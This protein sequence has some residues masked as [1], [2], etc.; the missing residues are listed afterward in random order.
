MEEE[1]LDV[2]QDALLIY[3]RQ[4]KKGQL[5]NLQASVGTYLFGIG[6]NLLRKLKVKQKREIQLEENSFS[7]DEPVDVTIYHKMEEDHNKQIIKAA[8]QKLGEK[9]RAL[10]K[11]VFYHNF[12][13]ESVKNRMGY[14]SEEVARSRKFNCLNEL[15]AK[16][17]NNEK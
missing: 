11:L 17:K 4:W 6:K 2:F 3:F 12:T 5:D 16:F 7:P 10:L 15:R 9:C 13:M 1:A 14:S 8:L